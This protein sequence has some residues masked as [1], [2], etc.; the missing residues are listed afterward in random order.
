MSFQVTPTRLPGLGSWL[1]RK[2]TQLKVSELKSIGHEPGEVHS[3]LLTKPF[4]ST[5]LAQNMRLLSTFAAVGSQLR[6]LPNRNILDLGGGSAWVSELLAKIGFLPITVDVASTLLNLGRRRFA[7]NDLVARCVAADMAQLPISS[8][9]VGAVVV[10]DALHHVFDPSAVFKEAFRVLASGG[11]FIL[12][13]PGEGHAEVEKSIAEVIEYGV[14]EREIHL[15]EAFNMA[16][17]AGF[18]DVRVLPILEAGLTMTPKQ[19]ESAMTSSAD[20]WMAVDDQAPNYLASNLIRTMFSHPI[21]ICRKG[22]LRIDSSMPG[23]LLAAIE[24]FLARTG[25]RV[26]G[27]VRVQNCGDTVWLAGEHVGHVRLG[28]QLLTEERKLINQDFCRFP[29]PRD[30]SPG[31]LIEIGVDFQLP[32]ATTTYLLKVDLVDEGI[33]WFVD[34]G[35]RTAYVTL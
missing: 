25:G 11:V 31:E 26:H 15:R 30:I 32:D 9:S 19:V 20:D 10:F 12:A 4:A 3:Y 2:P 24:P 17:S 34:A 16:A 27:S 18:D 28:I 29:L 13:E 14:Q 22:S 6:G 1:A 21:L 35:S 8:G 23:R 5:N 33:A 7:S